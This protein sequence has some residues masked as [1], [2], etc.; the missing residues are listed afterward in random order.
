[1]KKLYMLA[2]CIITYMSG[3]QAW[4]ST[5]KYPYRHSYCKYHCSDIDAFPW[6]LAEYDNGQRCDFSYFD[7]R[8]V[9]I[10]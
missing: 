4:Y 10:R 1:M 6:F 7:R 2:L 9:S 8:R 3:M 5:K